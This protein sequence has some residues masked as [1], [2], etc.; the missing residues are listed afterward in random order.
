MQYKK[1]LQPSHASLCS[2][3]SLS[4]ACSAL[5]LEAREGRLLLADDESFA[6]PRDLRIDILQHPHL[7]SLSSPPLLDSDGPSPASFSTRLRS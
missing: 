2:K 7:T 4:G 3:D 1:V 6:E 5:I